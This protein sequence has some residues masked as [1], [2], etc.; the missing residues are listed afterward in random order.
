MRGAAR[1]VAAHAASLRTLRLYFWITPHPKS[2]HHELS[3]LEFGFLESVLLAAPLPALRRLD[4]AVEFTAADEARGL[5]A[6]RLLKR[7]S[8]PR[9]AR[10][11]LDATV[12]TGQGVRWLEGAH[13]PALRHLGLI[14]DYGFTPEWGS[15]S[16]LEAPRWTALEALD[17]DF[18]PDGSGMRVR[19]AA[20]SATLA[21]TLRRLAVGSSGWPFGEEGCA[22]KWPQLLSLEFP[23]Y[24]RRNLA[25]QLGPVRLP[26]LER[27]AASGA[28]LRGLAALRPSIPA[29]C[30]V[31]LHC[32]RCGHTRCPVIGCTRR[33]TVKLLSAL[34]AAWP[35]LELRR[36]EGED[37]TQ[38]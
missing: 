35:W 29:L 26:R 17:L 33:K 24:R 16:A 31:E 1:L 30:V 8:L 36:F 2:H 27:L 21:P 10:L 20:L 22:E 32:C 9:L 5:E 28:S 14:D 12:V 11:I 13:L 38:A 3:A 37:W 34:R 4:L 23:H 15:I 19:M 6:L 25:E 18:N 7:L